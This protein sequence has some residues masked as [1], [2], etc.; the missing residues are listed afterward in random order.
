MLSYCI[1][2]SYYTLLHC[3][4]SYCMLSYCMLYAVCSH[5]VC[6]HTVCCHTVCC[7]TVC[8]HIVCCHTV[9]YHTVCCQTVCCHTVCCYTVCWISGLIINWEQSVLMYTRRPRHGEIMSE[10]GSIG[11]YRKIPSGSQVLLILH[12][13]S[14]KNTL[15]DIILYF[16]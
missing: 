5:N 10:L 12:R 6:F 8:C 1:M 14:K 11:F 16:L 2:F 4:L 9:N 3:M 15:I 7:H 13:V